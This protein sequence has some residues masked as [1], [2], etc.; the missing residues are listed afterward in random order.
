[1]CIRSLLYGTSSHFGNRR[2]ETGVRHTSDPI[3]KN[4]EKLFKISSEHHASPPHTAISDFK[5][6]VPTLALVTHYKGHTQHTLTHT[7]HTNVHVY[8]QTMVRIRS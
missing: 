1:M 2:V 6:T 7:L 4:I 5:E 8:I 3:F